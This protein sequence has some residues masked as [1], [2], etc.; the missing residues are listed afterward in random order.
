MS[1][2][3]NILAI[4]NCRS[5]LQSLKIRSSIHRGLLL[6]VCVA[7]VSLATGQAPPA[8]AEKVLE[9]ARAVATRENKNVFIIFHA[10]WCGWCH[11]MDTAL[12]DPEVKKYFDDN[13][14]IRHLV[15]LE[16]KNKKDLENPGALDLLKKH[17][18]ESSGIP[19]WLVYDKNGQKLFDS[20]EK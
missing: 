19:F 10:S 18:E 6:T 13:Y 1:L 12:N 17:S 3:I 15:V 2:T 4:A 8:T 14:V 16:S 11:K 20:R 7:L 5:S 9:E